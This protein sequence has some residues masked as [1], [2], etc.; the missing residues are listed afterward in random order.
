MKKYY[1]ALLYT[2]SFLGLQVLATVIVTLVMRMVHVSGTTDM[3]VQTIIAASVISGVMVCA[4]FC[5]L[6]WCETGTYYLRQ[7]PFKF[8]CLTALLAV[9]MIIPMVTIEEI[10]P[11]ALQENHLEDVF[12]V[13]LSSAWGYIVIA[14]I[15]PLM[16]EMVF[17]GAILRRLLQ[18]GE[19]GAP[20]TARQ[21]WSGIALSSFLFAMI[22]GNPA[23]MPHAFVIGLLLG[24][25]Y[26]RTGSIIPGMVYH[27]VNNSIPF[28]L[29]FINPEYAVDAEVQEYFDG[30]VTL[31]AICF[32][33][34]ALMSVV[35]LALLARHPSG[36]AVRGQKGSAEV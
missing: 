27:W 4:L 32:A 23:Q 24:W 3:K 34:S 25:L 9:T 7:R 11:D 30:N 13:M 17:R 28:L 33:V 22:H 31:Y 26:Y 6:R 14:L 36:F 18:T 20:L 5:A 10:L 12:S 19:S 15:A 21:I 35:L 2:F 1:D 29:V 8:L 16:E